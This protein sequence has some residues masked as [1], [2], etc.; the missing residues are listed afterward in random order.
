MATSTIGL[1]W[2]EPYPQVIHVGL[3]TLNWTLHWFSKIAAIQSYCTQTPPQILIAKRT[4]LTAHDGFQW[5]VESRKHLQ[6]GK[7]PIL[8]GAIDPVGHPYQTSADQAYQLGINGCFGIVFALEG[9]DI[10]L[11]RLLTNPKHVGLS[12]Q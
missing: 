8:V 11:R 4:L 12:D 1:L 5:A 6:L 10:M 3:T 9:I 2:T 7:I